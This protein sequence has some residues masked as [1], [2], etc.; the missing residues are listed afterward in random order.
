MLDMMLRLID[1]MDANPV[2][3]RLFGIDKKEDATGLTYAM[4]AIEAF[5]GNKTNAAIRLMEYVNRKYTP[6]A[7]AENPTTSS[8]SIIGQI[9][10]AAIDKSTQNTAT[11]TNSG[12]NT[13]NN[14]IEIYDGA[15]AARVIDYLELQQSGY[16][17]PYGTY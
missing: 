8:A 9:G 6:S 14:R 10:E 7:G 1:K 11:V 16:Q 17:I 4:D 3:R 2:T 15:G 13:F 12:G 5:L